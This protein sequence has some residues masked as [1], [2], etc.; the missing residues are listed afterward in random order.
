M[1]VGHTWGMLGPDHPV[2]PIWTAD[3]EH[4]VLWPWLFGKQMVWLFILLSGFALFWSEENRTLTGRTQ[5][6]LRTYLRRRAWRIL[7]TYYVSVALGLLVVVGLSDWLL[8]PS[9]SL[10]TFGPVT[11]AGLASHIFLLQNLSPEWMY[12][13]NPPLWSISVE[14]QLYVI[15]PLLLA[16]K[17][18]VN[19]YF[20]AIIMLSGV[21]LMN[22]LIDSPVF[23]LA[24]WFLLGAILAFV[25]RRREISNIALISIAASCI[26]V[27]LLRLPQLSGLVGE[28]I[29]MVG[30]SA[31]TVGLVRV[32]PGS[33]NLPTRP[34]FQWLG[35]R[36]YSLYAVHFPIALVVWS[37]IGRLDLPRVVEVAATIVLGTCLS[38][39]VSHIVYKFV[40]RP[41]MRVGGTGTAAPEV[42][43]TV[44]KRGVL[45]AK[46]ELRLSRDGAKSTIPLD[47]ASDA[48]VT[49]TEATVDVSAEHLGNRIT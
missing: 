8:A 12:Q 36:S 18:R 9:P 28:G 5:T 20:S 30:F 41:S 19:I 7:P 44:S 46:P 49:L 3:L 1:A 42:A 47:T 29:W 23:S 40:E 45:K 17:R 25:A 48:E 31:L 2:G 38:L 11:P 6:T 34:S 10:R 14:A 4:L 13:I 26:A 21:L 16:L 39:L 43:G 24:H 33:W 37:V 27:G 22:K 35:A 15:F 32:P